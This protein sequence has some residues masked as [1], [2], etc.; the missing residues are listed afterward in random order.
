MVVRYGILQLAKFVERGAEV[1]VRV[2][3][4]GLDGERLAVAGDSLIQPPQILE[5]ITKVV[6]RLGEIGLDGESLL[7]AGDGLV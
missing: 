6:V 5:R 3:V 2:G 4:I 7:V 1:I